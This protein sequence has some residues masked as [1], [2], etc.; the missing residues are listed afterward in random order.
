V[1]EDLYAGVLGAR[2][3]R[4]LGRTGDYRRDA[5]SRLGRD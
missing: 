3:V 1:G 4:A 5:H 2:L